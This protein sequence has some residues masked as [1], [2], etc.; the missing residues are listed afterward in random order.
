[1]IPAQKLLIINGSPVDLVAVLFL[2]RH[3]VKLRIILK[4]R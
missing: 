4:N 1:M 3:D 2:N